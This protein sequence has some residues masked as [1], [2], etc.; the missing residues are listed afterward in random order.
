M[1][2]WISAFESTL[3]IRFFSEL[4]TLPRSGRI[5]WNWR[6]RASMAEP[7][8]EL[9]STRYISASA[10]SRVWQSASFPGSEPPSRALLRRVSSRAL[11]AACR[12]SR[13]AIPFWMICFASVGFSSRNS[14]S[15][16]FTVCSTRPRTHGLP[17][18]VFVW[19]SN[20]GSRSFTEM[21]AARPSRTSS[22]SRFSSFSLRRP[23]SR[24]YLLS[25]PVSAALKPERCVPPSC[26]LM[27]FANEKTDST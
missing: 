4:I 16:A 6:S 11:R 1:I 24:A 15:F 10:G 12:A 5:A 25:V 20:C 26:V 7:P 8:A 3:L 27:L 9:P 19:P 21:T 18:F 23:L 13:A 2:A 22:P 14:A 17:S